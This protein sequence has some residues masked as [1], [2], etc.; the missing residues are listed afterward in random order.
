MATKQEPETVR[1][2]NINSGAIVSVVAE[3]AERMGSQW[4]PVKA[5]TA[6]K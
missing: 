5:S 3:K 6:K 1:L 4:E 2:R